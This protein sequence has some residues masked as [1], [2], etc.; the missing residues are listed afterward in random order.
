MRD[1]GFIGNQFG[2]ITTE[3]IADTGTEKIE[4]KQKFQKK[5]FYKQTKKEEDLAK[6]LL[7]TKEN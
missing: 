6:H 3:K 1:R 2:N 4:F 5:R 7:V